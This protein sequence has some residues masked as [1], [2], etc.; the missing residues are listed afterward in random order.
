MMYDFYEIPLKLKQATPHNPLYSQQPLSDETSSTQQ[1]QSSLDSSVQMWLKSVDR[2]KLVLGVELYAR[3]Y[4]IFKPPP[5]RVLGGDEVM[6]VGSTVKKAG[7]PGEHTNINGI[8]AYFEMCGRIGDEAWT[9]AWLDVERVPFMYERNNNDT[10]AF[11]EDSDSIEAKCVYVNA[12][13]LAGLGL[14]SIDMDDF[15]GQF[16]QQGAF[17]LVSTARDVLEPEAYATKNSFRLL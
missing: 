15:S 10:V 17:P 4:S 14:F 5:T 1:Q 2:E 16:C 9:Y 13:G 11:Y 7:A 3:T 12:N 6:V 8:L